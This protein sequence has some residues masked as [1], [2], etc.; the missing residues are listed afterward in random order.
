MLEA[1]GKL[2]AMSAVQ[3][4]LFNK[5]EE[6]L[7]IL[8]S[9]PPFSP[10][11]ESI[12]IAEP[13]SSATNLLPQTGSNEVIVNGT[14]VLIMPSKNPY[15]FGL[16]LLDMFFSR[17]ELSMSLLFSSSKSDRA[18]LDQA[19]VSRIIEIMNKR[20]QPGDWD[21]K[22]FVAKANQKCRDSKP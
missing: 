19:K 12:P 11:A 21:M 7:N 10:A 20:Y 5:M 1:I 13:Q 14:N 6:I 18:S 4:T 2:D 17:E 22:T 9:K 15:T 3:T 16:T 8:K